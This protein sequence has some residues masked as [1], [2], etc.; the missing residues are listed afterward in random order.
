MNRNQLEEIQHIADRLD[1]L[2][3]DANYQEEEQL[4]KAINALDRILNRAR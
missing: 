4:N 1:D 3:Y 2:A